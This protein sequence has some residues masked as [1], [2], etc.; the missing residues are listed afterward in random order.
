VSLSLILGA[1]RAVSNPPL[2]VRRGRRWRS[3]R[4]DADMRPDPSGS[5][6]ITTLWVWTPL[7]IRSRERTR[8][9]SGATARLVLYLWWS[10]SVRPLRSSG[11]TWEKTW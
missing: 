9:Q 4:Y 11:H 8:P 10:N 2:G 5:Q 3:R 7:S 1:A 6:M